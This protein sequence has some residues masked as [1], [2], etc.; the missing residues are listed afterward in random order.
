MANVQ[1]KEH[2]ESDSSLMPQD[3]DWLHCRASLCK[4]NL[5]SSEKPKSDKERKLVCF[6]DVSS[7][8]EKGGDQKSPSDTGDGFDLEEKEI[9]VIKDENENPTNTEGSVCFFKPGHCEKGNVMNWLSDD[10]QK[11]AIGFHHA[12]TPANN[13]QKLNPFDSA[14]DIPSPNNATSCNRSGA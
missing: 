1:Q 8:N 6:V 10:L 5:F 9:V 14:E 2:S 13:P 11:Y 7:L 3:I 12:L 4:V